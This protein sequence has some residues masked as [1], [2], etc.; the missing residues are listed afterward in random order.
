[1]LQ[2]EGGL[3]ITGKCDGAFLPQSP[4]TFFICAALIVSGAY[5]LAAATDKKP[6]IS[7]EQAVKFSNYFL[8][9]RSVQLPKGSYSLLEILQILTSNKVGLLFTKSQYLE[10]S[11]KIFLTKD[12]ICNVIVNQVIF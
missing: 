10:V 1:M 4:L 8:S 12:Q 2:F 11:F 9:R 5:K 6:P 3:S 7:G